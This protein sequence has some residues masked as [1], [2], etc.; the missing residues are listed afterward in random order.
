M[1][2]S[3]L[4]VRMAEPSRDKACGAPSSEDTAALSTELWPRLRRLECDLSP[5]RG[6]RDVCTEQQADIRFRLMAWILERSNRGR[7]PPTY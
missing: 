3:P 1:G 6:P 5:S 2:W 4:N 7:I